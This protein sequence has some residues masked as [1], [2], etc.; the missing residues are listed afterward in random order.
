MSSVVS[1]LRDTMHKLDFE[2]VEDRRHAVALAIE[3][4]DLTTRALG[5]EDVTAEIAHVRAQADAIV[6]KNGIVVGQRIR[7]VLFGALHKAMSSVLLA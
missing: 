5:D 4:A 7:G 1:L 6:A 2:T 3:Y